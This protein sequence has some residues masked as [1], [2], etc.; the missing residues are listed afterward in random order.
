MG[1][2]AI[3]ARTVPLASPCPRN[4]ASARKPSLNFLRNPPR[5]RRNHFPRSKPYRLRYQPILH[6]GNNDGS[7][8]HHPAISVPRG[9]FCA[10]RPDFL[11]QPRILCARPFR[12]TSIGRSRTKAAHE[13]AR[14]SNFICQRLR[15]R[16]H[17]SLRRVVHGH[18]RSRLESRGRRHVQDATRLAALHARHEQL[19]EKG[20]LANLRSRG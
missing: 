2:L 1:S 12:K 17:I 14:S 3:D 9:R 20:Q 16:K 6:S 19:G 5:D 4:P 18:E 15:K 8:S 13:H 10:H 7:P 11:E